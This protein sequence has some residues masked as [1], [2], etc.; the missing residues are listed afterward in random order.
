VDEFTVVKIDVGNR[1]GWADVDVKATASLQRE[2]AESK[3]TTERWR[4]TLRREPQ[5]WVLQSPPRG[6]VYLRRD[7]AVRALANRLAMMSS[8]QG[9]RQE[10]RITVR[11][12]DELLAEKPA[13]AP[14]SSSQ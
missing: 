4:L 5:G 14:A 8:A 7:Q 9:N 3:P 2:G 12:L 10:L 6:R 13:K 1:T 11:M